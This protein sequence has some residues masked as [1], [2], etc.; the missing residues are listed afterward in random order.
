M[1]AINIGDQ[2][3]SDNAHLLNLIKPVCRVCGDQIE[4]LVV[5]RNDYELSLSFRGYC[6]GN[7]LA[8][9]VPE[10]SL[11]SIRSQDKVRWLRNLLNNNLSF[12]QDT[13]EAQAERRTDDAGNLPFAERYARERR[14]RDS[15]HQVQIWRDR[16]LTEAQ[17]NTVFSSLAGDPDSPAT[18]VHP[19]PIIQVRGLREGDL[20]WVGDIHGREICPAIRSNG[21]VVNIAGFLFPEERSVIVRVRGRN[22][23]PYETPIT[24]DPENTI[25]MQ[26]PWV[27]DGPVGGSSAAN[28]ASRTSSSISSRTRRSARETARDLVDRF[29]TVSRPQEESI[30]PPKKPK[31]GKKDKNG[32]L[33]RR[34]DV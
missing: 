12:W 32:R 31:E 10:H 2:L 17:Q 18:P 5:Y 22:R 28:S 11:S 15:D 34:I 29:I 8:I 13:Q 6:H 9:D 19:R 7:S 25:I 16:M 1:S 30:M 14:L 21:S 26:V 23:R 4:R 33:L 24:L 20:V 3:L 27:F